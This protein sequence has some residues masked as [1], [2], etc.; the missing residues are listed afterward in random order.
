MGPMGQALGQGNVQSDANSNALQYSGLSGLDGDD[1]AEVAVAVNRQ[2]QIEAQRRESQARNSGG[3]KEK[4]L[5]GKAE[6]PADAEAL[7]QR[8][9]ERLG[10]LEQGQSPQG[11]MAD[12]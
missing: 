6:K 7:R 5:G 1:E 12:L 11:D 9:L 4:K 10:F 2:G 3:A 8:R